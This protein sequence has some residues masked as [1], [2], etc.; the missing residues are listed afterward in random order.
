MR[1][2]VSYKADVN[3]LDESDRDA[4]A[5]ARY[6]D[7]NQVSLKSTLKPLVTAGA[8]QHID[9]LVKRGEVNECAFLSPLVLDAASEQLLR[10]AAEEHGGRPSIPM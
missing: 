4:S 3:H 10:K 6:G 8:V 9:A 5:W 7:S 1:L 2:L